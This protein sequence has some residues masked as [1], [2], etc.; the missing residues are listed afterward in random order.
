LE[1][2]WVPVS[3]WYLNVLRTNI[4]R[5][6]VRSHWKVLLNIGNVFG[7]E[8]RS[9][10]LFSD[11]WGRLICSFWSLTVNFFC[12]SKRLYRFFVHASRDYSFDF[13]DLCI[14][15]IS[16]YL[17]NFYTRNAI[18]YIIWHLIWDVGQFLQAI[19]ID[20]FILFFLLS[21]LFCT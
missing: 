4:Y 13:K 12:F 7:P 9:L 18:K 1:R 17:F 21:F 19:F 11:R 15:L 14:E 5:R 10:P 6:S 3:Y 20:V 16:T 8:M 2:L